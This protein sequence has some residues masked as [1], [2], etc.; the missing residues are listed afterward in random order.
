MK[1]IK[2]IT[3]SLI[4]TGIFSCKKD[5][6]I[7]ETPKPLP[8]EVIDYNIT[9]TK[10]LVK[11]QTIKGVADYCITKRIYI[12]SGAGL[13]IEPGVIIEFTQ[14]A[15]ID[16][17]RTGSNGYIKAIGGGNNKILFTGKT[18]TP[19]FWRGIF[20]FYDNND[21]RNILDNCIVEYAGS[22]NLSGGYLNYKAGVGVGSNP[23]VGTTGLLSLKNTTIKNTTGKGFASDALGIN[24]FENNVFNNNSQE[25]IVA[26][27]AQFSKIDG[28]TFFS[29]NGADGV[30][31]SIHPSAKQYINDNQIHTWKKL[32]GNNLYHIIKSVRVSSGG[33]KLSPGVKIEMGSNKQFKID[34][35]GYFNAIGTSAEPIIIQGTVLGTPSW[36]SLFFKTNN[37]LN[38]MKYCEISEA[39]VGTIFSSGCNGAA[40]VGLYYWSGTTSSINITNSTIKNGGGC[41]IFTVA[42]NL[43]NLTQSGNTFTNLVGANICN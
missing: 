38:K 8:C 25:A 26:S 10:T 23:S 43:S 35:T 29:N 24:A 15:G 31:L 16:A 1:L 5:E 9:T 19:G 42:T 12:T 11:R 2:L 3:L 4:L 41:G 27:F 34:G 30:S 17:G 36:N 7:E 6:K 22:E 13:I 37:P 40:S 21:V 20:I 14:N 28:N 18:K 39:G 33:L 32:S